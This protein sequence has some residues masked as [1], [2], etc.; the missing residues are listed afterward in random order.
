MNYELK[1]VGLLVACLAGF[2]GFGGVAGVLLLFL[3]CCM[4]I[5][6]E[7]KTLTKKKGLKSVMKFWFWYIVYIICLAIIMFLATHLHPL[8]PTAW[9]IV[10][11]LF[12]I[13][14]NLLKRNL[15]LL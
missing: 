1:S 14:I 6:N 8:F 5:H 7:V 10:L 4:F 11:V 15:V 9:C 12:A 13:D 3:S 2:A